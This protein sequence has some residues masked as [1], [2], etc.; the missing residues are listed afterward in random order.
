MSPD[1][2]DGILGDTTGLLPQPDPAKG[3]IAILECAGGPDKNTRGH[4]DDTIPIANGVIK[5]NRKCAP[6]LY[7]DDD[8]DDVLEFLKGCDGYVGRL[9]PTP[10]SKL[11]KVLA[12]AEA[13]GVLPLALESDEYHGDGA[14]LGDVKGVRPVEILDG[15][16]RVNALLPAPANPRYKMAVI[17]FTAPGGPEMNTDKDKTGSRYDS[18]PIANG[19]IKAGASCD[20]IDYTPDDHTGFATKLAAYDGV[21]VRI[22][23]GQLSAPGVVPGAQQN[24]DALMMATVAKGVPVWSSPAVQTQLG[25]KDALVAIKGLSCGLPDT[26]AYYTAEELEKGFKTFTAFQPRVIKQNRG[27][28]GEGIWLVWLEDKPYCKNLGDDHTSL[29][30]PMYSFIRVSKRSCVPAVVPCES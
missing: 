4:R 25:A 7:T 11:A 23:P 12:E 18:T 20:L 6:I 5:Q 22:N 24:F 8:A 29:P 19:V 21:I 9:S 2:L 13:A 16:K 10:G 3:K 28:A 17:G 26:A 27:S 15:E 1:T 30:L 14:A